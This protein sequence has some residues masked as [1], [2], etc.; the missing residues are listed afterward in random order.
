MQRLGISIVE[1]FCHDLSSR[2]RPRQA[3]FDRI[4]LDAP[5]SGLGV[6]R[7]NPDAKWSVSEKDLF[8]LHDIQIRLLENLAPLLKPSGIIVY[9]VCSTE[10]EETESVVEAFLKS[11]PNFQPEPLHS[12]KLLPSDCITEK[13]FFRTY[14]KPA[15][16]GWFF[17]GT[18]KENKL[19][20]ID[21]IYKSPFIIYK[22]EH[23]MIWNSIP[24]LSGFR[25]RFPNDRN[26]LMDVRCRFTN[27]KLWIKK[28]SPLPVL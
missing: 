21:G 19:I 6:L 2:W 20:R 9:V 17:F 16:D 26:L 23:V 22:N 15:F 27:T 25:G 14:P 12:L 11:N 10:P 28:E 8:R 1:T 18:T 24:E 7:R 3:P 4:L 5:C 13:G